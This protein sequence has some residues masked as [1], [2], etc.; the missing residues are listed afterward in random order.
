[1]KD[2]KFWQEP[3]IMHNLLHHPAFPRVAADI[4][5]FPFACVHSVCTEIV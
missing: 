4:L 2:R 1:L 3:L 5:A